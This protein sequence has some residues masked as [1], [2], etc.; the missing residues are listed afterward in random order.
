MLKVQKKRGGWERG[1]DRVVGKLHRMAGYWG[2]GGGGRRAE[3]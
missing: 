1:G 2:G 3:K